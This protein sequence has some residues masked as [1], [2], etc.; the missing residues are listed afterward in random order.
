MA[1]SLACSDTGADCPGAFTTEGKD[2][3]VKHVLMHARHAHP[4]LAANPELGSMV[5]P[6]IKQV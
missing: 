6:L 2:E 4:D 5:Q 1:F 3:L